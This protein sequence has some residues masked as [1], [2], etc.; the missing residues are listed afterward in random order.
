MTQEFTYEVD[1]QKIIILD[2]LAGHIFGKRG[3]GDQPTH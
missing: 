2:H 1:G 3:I